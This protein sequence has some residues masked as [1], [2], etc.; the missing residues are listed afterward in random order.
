MAKVLLYKKKLFVWLDE[1]GCN[2]KSF[3]RKYGYAIRGQ[4]PQC[5]KLLVRGER[6][7][8]IAAIATD[9]LVSLELTT[10]TVNSLISLEEV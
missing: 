1:T 8:A 10:G 7:S 5:H 6:I 2:N 4:V 9:G 3:M